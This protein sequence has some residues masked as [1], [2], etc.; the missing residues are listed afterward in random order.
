MAAEGH[1]KLERKHW[2]VLAAFLT[3]LATQFSSIEHGWIEAM[4]PRFVGGVLLQIATV[5]TALYVGP[6][7]K[8]K[9]TRRTDPAPDGRG[10]EKL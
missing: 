5:L 7:R 6:P 9:F 10:E 8:G 3:A 1:R 4:T 2:V